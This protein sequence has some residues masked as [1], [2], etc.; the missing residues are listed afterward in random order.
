VTN[1]HATQSIGS[2]HPLP[3]P[4][5]R[6]R[7][8]VTQLEGVFVEQLF[9]AMRATVPEDGLTSGGAGE[10]M[11]TGLMDQHLA[12]SVPTSW[13]R[14]L[15]DALTRQLQERRPLE[16]VATAAEAGTVAPH[17]APLVERRTR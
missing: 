13:D 3:S 2:T 1:I 9:K 5:A 15:A 12:A 16:A 8:A 7:D 10:E 17:L 14:S 11:F 4:E 6:L